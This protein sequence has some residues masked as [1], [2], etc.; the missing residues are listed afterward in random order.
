MHDHD[1]FLAFIWT[2]LGAFGGVVKVLVQL[3]SMQTLPPKGNILWLL[4][5]NSLVSGFSG[6]MGAIMATQFTADDNIHV[7]AAGICGYLG[8]AALDLISEWFKNRVKKG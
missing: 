7:I 8:V 6:F 4:F 3:L 1:P 2:A 5:A